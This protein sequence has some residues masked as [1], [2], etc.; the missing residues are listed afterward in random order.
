MKL[1]VINIL[2][3]HKKDIITNLK[4]PL[5]VNIAEARTSR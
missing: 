1:S 5:N 3:H 2:P 4:K